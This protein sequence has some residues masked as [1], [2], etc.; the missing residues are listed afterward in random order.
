MSPVTITQLPLLFLIMAL[1][2]LLQLTVSLLETDWPRIGTWGLSLMPRLLLLHKQ[3]SQV[4]YPV[5]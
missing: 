3:V 2:W 4:K 1:C 5:I